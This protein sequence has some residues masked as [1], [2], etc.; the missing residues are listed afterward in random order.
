MK[1]VYLLVIFLC[2]SACNR[3]SEA[4][5]ASHHAK[6]WEPDFTWQ[7]EQRGYKR[8]ALFKQIID[9]YG[10]QDAAY[11]NMSSANVDPEAKATFI[12]EHAFFY[13]SKEINTT[14]PMN[15]S[16]IEWYIESGVPIFKHYP[17]LTPVISDI[18]MARDRRLLS[19]VERFYEREKH[20]EIKA[21][22]FL[23]RNC[24]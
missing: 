1:L 13:L 18:E 10:D 19:L 12:E 23:I 14:T 21:I 3:A 16:R 2:L 6:V 5:C 22:D 8:I 4:E 9:M 24:A 11:L 7:D 15:Y 20:E 17:A